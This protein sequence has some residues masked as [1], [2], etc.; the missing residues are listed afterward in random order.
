MFSRF[1]NESSILICWCSVRRPRRICRERCQ[2]S[3]MLVLPSSFRFFLYT[4]FSF[5]LAFIGSTSNVTCSSRQRR[6]RF[7]LGRVHVVTK[8]IARSTT[9]HQIH[10]FHDISPRNFRYKTVPQACVLLFL[11]STTRRSSDWTPLLFLSSP[12]VPCAGARFHFSLCSTHHRM[13][14]PYRA[15]PS[16]RL[17]CRFECGRQLYPSHVVGSA[18]CVAIRMHGVLQNCSNVR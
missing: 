13:S 17:L 1:L 9:L 11:S 16:C 15:F 8:H 6:L 18:T 12:R 2:V 5:F 14:G 4:S 3:A 7:S 10:R